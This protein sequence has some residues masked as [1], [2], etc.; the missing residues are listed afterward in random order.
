MFNYLKSELRKD[1]Q[2][3]SKFRDMFSLRN[4]DDILSDF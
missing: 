4:H 1:S 3:P 2:S